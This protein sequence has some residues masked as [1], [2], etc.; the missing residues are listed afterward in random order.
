MTL[1]HSDCC[2]EGDIIMNNKGLDELDEKILDVIRY[3]ARKSYEEIAK[4]V[5]VSRTAVKN[6]M[7]IME[8]NNIIVGYETI[9]RR[10][11]ESQAVKFYV[12][13]ETSPKDFNWV[14]NYLGES[15]FISE[16]YISGGSN[17]LHAIGLAPN[18]VTMQAYT[19][20]VYRELDMVRK[21]T[22]TVI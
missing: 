4:K 20:K 17:H 10:A 3:D 8:E 18:V 1:Q 16:L 14:K 11:N 9:I 7:K 12:D 6:R 13:V 5:R 19:N 21:L 2:F 22:I 15:S